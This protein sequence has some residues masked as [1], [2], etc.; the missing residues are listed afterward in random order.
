MNELEYVTFGAFFEG[1]FNPGD[2]F[3]YS[4]DQTGLLGG[5]LW[6]AVMGFGGSYTENGFGSGHATITLSR[7]PEPSTV[8]LLGFG[9][10]A[11]LGQHRLKARGR[12]TQSC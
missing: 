12:A 8:L 9:L 6:H 3:A 1:M 2:S 10:V 11:I 5:Q 7:V 4:W